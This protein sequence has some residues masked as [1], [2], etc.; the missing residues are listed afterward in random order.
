MIDVSDH[1]RAGCVAV[2]MSYSVAAN[3]NK[4]VSSTTPFCTLS[5]TKAEFNFGMD[6]EPEITTAGTKLPLLHVHRIC[7]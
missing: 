7:R 4:C 3:G 2:G 6:E 5:V 1:F